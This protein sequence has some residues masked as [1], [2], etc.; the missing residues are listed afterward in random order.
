MLTL[1]LS[2]LTPSCRQRSCLIEAALEQAELRA[3]SRRGGEKCSV[4]SFLRAVLRLSFSRAA[5]LISLRD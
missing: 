2:V 4:V 1:S 3:L 5:A